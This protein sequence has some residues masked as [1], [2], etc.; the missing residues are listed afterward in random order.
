MLLRAELRFREAMEALQRCSTL[1]VQPAELFPLFPD[2]TEPWAA[3]AGSAAPPR[4]RWGLHR[5]LTDLRALV[6]RRLAADAAAADGAPL[7]NGSGADIERRLVA[8][9]QKCV[10]D[11]L[12]EV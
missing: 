4:P 11:Y 12:L 1:V 8:A 6:R 10:A 5:P 7:E 2:E 9:A 3:A